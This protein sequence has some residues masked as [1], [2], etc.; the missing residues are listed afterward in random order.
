MLQVALVLSCAKLRN[1]C[2]F[3]QLVLC[4]RR[5]GNACRAA[6]AHSVHALKQTPGAHFNM[7]YSV[8]VLVRTCGAEHKVTRLWIL[9]VRLHS[10]L[11][12]AVANWTLHACCATSLV[13]RRP[14]G[15][16]ACRYSANPVILGTMGTP[17][18]CTTACAGCDVHTYSQ[19]T[20]IAALQAGL[21]YAWEFD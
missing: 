6:A 3:F 16:P 13:S 11:M 18:A 8:L 14:A 20:Q 12:L 1:P 17:M 21:H 2:Q 19:S 10:C 7:W 4:C 15:H 5:Q 9:L